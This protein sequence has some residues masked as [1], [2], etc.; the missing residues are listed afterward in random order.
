MSN[1]EDSIV[2]YTKV[3]SLFE[4]LS[5]IGSPG[6]DGL[7]MM[8]EDP[9]A[10][11]DAALQAPPS[12]DY[13]PGLEHPPS[14]TYAPE[15]VLKP[16]YPEL[17]PLEDDDEDEDKEE[18]EEHSAPADSIPPP[19]VH[20][21]TTRISIPVQAPTPLWSE[22]EINR[23]L[24][25]P[26][27]PPSP[28]SLWSSPLPQIPSPPLHVSSPPLPA[29]PTYPLGYRAAMIWLR[30]KTPS[31]SHPPPPIVLPHTRASAAMLRAAAPSTYI[32]A[33]QSETPPSGTPPLL[34]IPLPTSSP[35]LLLPS[36]SHR[37]D[38]PLRVGKMDLNDHFF[39]VD[40]FACPAHFLWHTAKKLT[41]NP[42]LIAADFN[43]QD[44]A[45]LV[46][47]PSPFWKFLEEFLCLVGLSRH[48]TLDEETYP[49]FFDK[50]R[51]NIDI[52]A[53]IHTPDPTKVKLV[54]QERKD[55]EPRLLETTVS[56]TVPLLPVAPDR[57]ESE[58]D[59]SV[60]KLFDE[61]GSGTQMEQGDSAGGEGGQGINVQPV[62][63]TT[64]TVAEDVIRLQPRRQKKRKAT[65][66]DDGGPS[67]PLK[68]LRGDHG[69][70][71]GS[72]VGGKSRSAVQRL[73]VGA[74]QNAEVRG[75]LIPTLPFVT[76][77]VSA[78][79]EHDGGDH[80][81][82]VTGPNL[83]TISAPQRFVISSDSSHHSGANVAEAEAD[84][85]V[86][87][88]VPVMTTVTTTTPTAEPVVIVK[89]KTVKP[90]MFAADSSSAGGADPDA[91]VFSDLT[92]S[93]FLV[94]GIRTVVSPD[95]D[96]QKVYVPQWSVTNR[97]RLDD[98]RVCR[99][100][101]DEFAPPKFFASIRGMEHD[102][103]FTEFN[104]GAARLMSLS[105]EVR[106]RAEYNI[107]ENRRLKFVAIEQT[108]LLKVRDEEI[109]NLKAQL[110]LKE[111][112][113]AKA[114]CLR[115]ETS[116]LEAV[117]K[118]LQDEVQTLKGRNATLEKEK[119]E[120]DVKVA[121]LAALVK[122]KEHE[123]A[124]LDVVVTS[125]RSQNDN[126]IHELKISF[127]RL[128]ENLYTEFIEMALHLE[129]KFH[130]YLLTTIAGHRW[131][132]TY[133][134][135]VVITKCLNSLEYLS[136]LGAAINKA[137]EKGM[138]DGLAAGVTHGQ[139][140]KV[141]ADVAAYNPSAEAD[142]M[143][144]LQQLQNVNFALLAELKSNKDSS[145]E[146]LMNILRM[147]ETLAERLGLNESQPDV[148][149]LTVPIH[150]SP[151]QTVVGATALLLA[152]Y[153]SDSRTFGIV[154]GVTSAL[155]TNFASASLIPFISTNDYEIVR[156]DGQEGTGAESQSVADGNA[157]PFPH[158]DDVDL[159]VL[160]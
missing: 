108:E 141:L 153:I 65:V 53:F 99:E 62:T 81:D 17:M 116:K 3:S 148:D 121:D 78:T 61:G 151:D 67:H 66:A 33:P 77:F 13:V 69:T 155:S 132:L 127:A 140:G 92:G 86:R 90:S 145:V 131:L 60:D 48:Y 10:Y 57:D 98:G 35:P 21:T 29:S 46:A 47:H 24:A 55:D 2:T 87:S 4:G 128:Q 125:V 152:L 12:P 28:L 107:K 89:H 39:W 41:R 129:E 82:S 112:E 7:P 83:R 6:V 117:K 133:G 40:E 76:S 71:S 106:M 105:A 150:H 23:L 63:K 91:S 27:P 157:D 70:P 156:S 59:A 74:V 104:V 32:L 75:E 80:T 52:F 43:A 144:A 45:T 100:M 20:H 122:V 142:Y 159:N 114:I 109:E 8:P 93:D 30:A 154:L 44:Y 143:S 54:E 115:A 103:L 18:E 101:V 137:I 25:I 136:A 88:S 1:S 22:A 139:E 146:T 56:R 95:T 158:V 138:Q 111:A 134:M 149:Q 42:A 68:K 102:Q 49:L 38:V 120:L 36:M 26:S 5:D 119:N 85:L 19:P 79:P 123:V 14:P 118:S 64:D 15:F 147:E 84:S 160:R 73:F 110:L 72:S 126:L 51:E 31:T 37:A 96:L 135:E 9:Y 11:V 34:P 113:S 94:G 16:V 97:S 130:P 124:A 50:D 58:L